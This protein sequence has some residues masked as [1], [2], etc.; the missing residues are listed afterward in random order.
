MSKDGIKVGQLVLVDIGSG[1]QEVGTVVELNCPHYEDEKE[2]D[3][4]IL[5]RTH[6]S[7]DTLVYNPED[8]QLWTE[9][10]P[11]SR[12]RSSSP[13]PALRSIVTP[14]PSSSSPYFEEEKKPAAKRKRLAAANGKRATQKATEPKP[15]KTVIKKAVSVAS[16][17][18]QPAA[19]LKE[20]AAV[21]QKKSSEDDAKKSAEHDTEKSSED[22]TKKHSESDSKKRMTIRPVSKLKASTQTSLSIESDAKKP[23]AKSTDDDNKNAVAEED[24]DI[25]SGDDDNESSGDD[26]DY[27][28]R[29]EYSPSGRATC[30]RCDET[31]PKGA[32]RICHVPLF[33]GKPGYTVYRHLPCAVLDENVKRL[34]DVGGW[35]KLTRPDRLKIAKRIAESRVELEKEK[36]ELQPD[37]L[38]QEK[39]S[40]EMRAS[41]PGLEADL[42]PFQVEGSSWMYCQEVNQPEVRGGILADEMGMVRYYVSLCGTKL[43]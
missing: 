2:L 11:S 20:A 15:H 36:E 40:G 31:I 39:F 1:V 43:L 26:S 34:Q 41:P 27:R 13:V 25:S 29:V 7:R 42:L 9:T 4:G 10:A 37:E 38:V 33:R 21:S 3:N 35:R 12:R 17:P 5:V 19:V 6:V 22:D 30:R 16:K 32:V 8:V 14:S 23:A 18:A 28:F 24:F